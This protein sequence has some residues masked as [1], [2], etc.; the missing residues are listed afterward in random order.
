V[1]DA[2]AAAG[3]AADHLAR[4]GQLT[5]LL[6]HQLGWAG[7]WAALWAAPPDPGS[8]VAPPGSEKVELLLKWAMWI[9]S[10]VCV[11]GVMFVAGRMAI[12]HQ[13][14]QGGEHAAGL[15]WVMFG[16]I[17]AGT[18]FSVVGLLI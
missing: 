15:G 1:Y 2:L 12:Q 6:L 7:H 13:R 14:G 3:E 9:V 11:G 8:G 4:A 17:L 18:A 16:C 5:D 10:A